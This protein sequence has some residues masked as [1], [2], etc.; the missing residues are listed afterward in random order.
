LDGSLRDFDEGLED[1]LLALEIGTARILYAAG[2][3]D[4]KEF[5]TPDDFFLRREVEARGFDWENREGYAAQIMR[6]TGLVRTAQ[7]ALKT[8]LAINLGQLTGRAV[9]H[10][11][12]ELGFAVHQGGRKGAEH[13]GT[14][15]ER[16]E[17]REN[18]R[19]LYEEERGKSATNTEAYQA[20]ERRTGIAARTVRRA[21]KGH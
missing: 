17:K 21:V 12:W 16:R 14:P 6:L 2:I 4:L 13:W 11:D 19:R 10:K 5:C 18:L 20:V 3:A 7:D 8:V 15:A 1:V 9:M